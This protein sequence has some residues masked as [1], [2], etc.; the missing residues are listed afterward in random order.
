MKT[1]N[2]PAALAVLVCCGAL[3]FAGCGSDDVSSAEASASAPATAPESAAPELAGEALQAP[4]EEMTEAEL[5]AL[6]EIEVDQGLLSVT[7]TLPKEFA[8][9]ITQA[10]I[11]KSIADGEIREG[12]LNEDG[13]VTYVM[14]K[15]QH[16][17]ALEDF[18]ASVDELVA[19][20]NTTNPGLYEEV[21]YSDDMTQFTIVVADRKKY[22]Q[23]MSMMSLSLLLGAGFYQIFYGVPEED[24]KVIIEY[25]DGKTGDVFDTFDSREEWEQ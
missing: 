13:T 22:E 10:D 7:I 5:E 2:R 11:D 25:V 17:A 16:D 18:R 4:A 15:S 20:E 19:E 14:S 9:D 1:G 24:R 8:A 3:L 6:G 21:T 23:S 12:Q